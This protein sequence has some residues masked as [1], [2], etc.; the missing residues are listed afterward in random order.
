MDRPV[1][2]DRQGFVENLAQGGTSGKMDRMKRLVIATTWV[3]TF[4]CCMGQKSDQP[5]NF[6]A[7]ADESE[8]KRA[9]FCYL[10][11]LVERANGV[12][13]QDRKRLERLRKEHPSG[14]GLEADSRR[15]VETMASDY[16]LEGAALDG[17]LFQRLL[18]R[19]DG[20]PVSLALAQ[21]ANES[22]WG[23]SR[24]ALEGHNYFGQWCFRKG[25]G[26]VPQKRAKGATYE[27]QAFSNVG[28]S[29]TAFIRNLN[30]NSSY[31]KFREIR[32]KRRSEGETAS[33][34]SLA[35]GLRDYSARRGEYVRT[36]RN[37]I[38]FNHLEQFDSSRGMEAACREAGG[39]RVSERPLS[40]KDPA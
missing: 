28:D 16:G 3:F 17:S 32:A 30:T 33:G 23:T 11:P 38:R 13:M 24:F 9:F 19:V 6:A 22:A 10:A 34:A 4:L 7:I 5:P 18:V 31:A 25:C 37:M 40:S 8:R 1:G 12:V 27:V 20:V 39:V 36:L 2:T 15:F 26:I 29:V 14:R 35:E 21:A